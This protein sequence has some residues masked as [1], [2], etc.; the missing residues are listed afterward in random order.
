MPYIS[1][2]ILFMMW[3]FRSVTVLG[4]P[5]IFN[6]NECKNHYYE[7]KGELQHIVGCKALRVVGVKKMCEQSTYN[8]ILWQVEITIVTTGA[9]HNIVHILVISK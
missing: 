8:V 9:Q 3:N 4:N 1:Y 5:L 2:F 7:Y 6:R